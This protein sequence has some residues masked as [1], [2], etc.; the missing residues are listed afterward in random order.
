MNS[1]KPINSL[2]MGEMICKLYR[3]ILTLSTKL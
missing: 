1:D 3:E 2:L